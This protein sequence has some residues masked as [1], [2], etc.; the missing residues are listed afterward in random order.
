MMFTILVNQNNELVVSPTSGRI[1]QR[2]NLVD[3]LHF[4][5]DKEYNDIPMKDCT[6]VMEYILPVSNKY[7]SEFLVASEEL[8]KDIGFQKQ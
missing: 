7:R 8:Y 2:S 4:L 6:V 3:S 5:V 1:M